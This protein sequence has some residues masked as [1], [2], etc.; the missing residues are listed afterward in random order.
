[1]RPFWSVRNDGIPPVLGTDVAV[2]GTVM[3]KCCIT[4][5][6]PI[7][8][9]F[10]FMSFAVSIYLHHFEKIP[11]GALCELRRLKNEEFAGELLAT[12]ELLVT[13]L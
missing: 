5:E 13:G 11:V 12:G 7:T 9:I 4:R 8:F 10:E 6:F 1:M 2:S 3:L